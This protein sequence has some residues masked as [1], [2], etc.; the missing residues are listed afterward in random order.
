M[1]K[2]CICIK[3][4][5][6]CIVFWCICMDGKYQKCTCTAFAM[7]LECICIKERCICIKNRCICIPCAFRLHIICCSGFGD[8][9]SCDVSHHGGWLHYCCGMALFPWCHNS[10]TG[11]RTR[12]VGMAWN[13]QIL[14]RLNRNNSCHHR[15]MKRDK[16]LFR[17]LSCY[18]WLWEIEPFTRWFGRRFFY[19]AIKRP[20]HL[21]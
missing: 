4:W 8:L 19:L 10:T 6:I 7:H 15:Q 12:Q 13:G 18:C 2:Q 20:V 5:C 11:K 17:S 21:A 14:R 1:Q 16:S 3:T 9:F